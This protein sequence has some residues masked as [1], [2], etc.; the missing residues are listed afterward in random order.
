[1]PLLTIYSRIKSEKDAS[2]S[3]LILD[4]FAVEELFAF[5]LLFAADGRQLTVFRELLFFANFY[6]TGL[7]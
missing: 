7:P 3:D 2:F 6:Q 5:G 1:M 4:L